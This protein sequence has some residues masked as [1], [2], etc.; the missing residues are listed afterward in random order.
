MKI[1]DRIVDF[2]RVKGSDFIPNPKN[3]RKHP[4]QQTDALRGVLS[5][6]GIADAVLA[7]ETDQGLMLID[8]HARAELD[9]DTAWPTLVLDVTQQESD[10]LLATF[11]AITGLATVDT[12]RLEDLLHDVDFDN[13]AV[14]KMLDNL[15]A[16]VGIKISEWN[17]EILDVDEIEPYDETKEVSV[18][19]VKVHRDSSEQTT[20]EI[21]TALT[22]AGVQFELSVF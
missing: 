12:D 9:P 21:E 11:D 20:K 6:V 14:G 10:E 5:K 2:R 8:G 19:R 7:V 1:K 18:I 17:D 13:E 4:E 15:A 3:W 16:S 22:N